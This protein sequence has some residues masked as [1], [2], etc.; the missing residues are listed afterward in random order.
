MTPAVISAHSSRPEL[1]V[2]C[3][4]GLWVCPPV[5]EGPRAVYLEECLEGLG[6][7]ESVLSSLCPCLLFANRAKQWLCK[8]ALSVPSVNV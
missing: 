5:P 4:P 1:S 2:S 6:L 3:S 7:G 8:R